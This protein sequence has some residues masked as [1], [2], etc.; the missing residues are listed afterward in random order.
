MGNPNTASEPLRIALNRTVSVADASAVEGAGAT[1]EFEVTLDAADDCETATV[2]WATADGTATAGEDYTAA[3]GTLTFEPGETTKTVSVAVLDDAAS[4][5]SETFTLQLSNA[6]GATLADAE[7]TGTITEAERDADPPSVT[8]TSESGAPVAGAFEVTVTFSEPTTGFEL[9][10]LEVMNGAA[11][12]MVSLGDGT[13]HAVTIVPDAGGLG[14]V[15]VTV[16]AGVAED[17]A[18]NPNTASAPFALAL[19]CALAPTERFEGLRERHDGVSPFRF[20]LRFSRKITMSYRVV[21]DHLLKV[22]GGT[23]TQARRLA[24]PSNVCWEVTVRP[25][26][27]RA[28]IIVLPG[29]DC[30]SPGTLCT[31]DGKPMF[32]HVEAVVP[33]PDPAVPRVSIAAAERA[34]TEGEAVV[35]TLRRAGPAAGTLAVDVSVTATG[36]VLGGTPP[37]VRGGRAHRRPAGGDRQRRH[38]GGRER[39]D[40][41]GRGGVGVRGGCRVGLGRYGRQRRRRGCAATDG[42]PPRDGGGA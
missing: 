21:R 30:D 33:G 28:V 9:S 22:S 38:R 34:V 15:T 20:E 11:S 23:V 26:T 5:G 10:E 17:A 41:V 3:S 27:D 4:E 18:G 7:A 31:W 39:G 19:P 14:A 25:K 24:R 8:V 32:G 37:C 13:Q 29:L 40:G 2:D 12:G 6:S 1:I 42:D 36:A 35:F 16:P